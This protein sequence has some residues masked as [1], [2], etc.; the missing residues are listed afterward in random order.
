MSEYV[1]TIKV[2]CPRCGGGSV[3]KF[4]KHDGNPVWRGLCYECG[5]PRNQFV[6]TPR[7]TLNAKAEEREGQ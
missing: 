2:R 1:Q 4:G 6:S 5:N 7:N 3:I